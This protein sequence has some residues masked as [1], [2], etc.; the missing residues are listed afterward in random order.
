MDLE[1]RMACLGDGL[2]ECIPDVAGFGNLFERIQG[3]IC[4]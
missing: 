2:C 1:I 3:I 4:V